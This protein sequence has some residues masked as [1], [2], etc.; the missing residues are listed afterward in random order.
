MGQRPPVWTPKPPPGHA[1][2][3]AE[4]DVCA[5]LRSGLVEALAETD[6]TEVDV[7]TVCE[8]AGIPEAAF[9][10]HYRSLD[11]CV[12]D[13]YGHASD[14]VYRGSVAAFGGPGDWR[15]RMTRAIQSMLAGMLA[16]PGATRLCFLEVVR[17]PDIRL[18]EERAAQRERFVQ[19][20]ASA[21]ER[22]HGVGLPRLHFEFLVGAIVHA[23]HAELAAGG[24]GVGAG[25]RI[26]TMLDLLEPV[27]A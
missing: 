12:L 18:H 6:L 3:N 26:R 21:Y 8:R 25:P 15:D 20:L 23:V 1:G 16:S 14:D 9:D 7:A 17:T 2:P 24:A 19:L 13:A 10:D 22:E 5:G 27:T 11:D 4:C